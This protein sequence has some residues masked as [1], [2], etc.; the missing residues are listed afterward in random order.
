MCISLLARCDQ[1]RQAFVRTLPEFRDVQHPSHP[2]SMQARCVR[3]RQ[4]F[5]RTLPELEMRSIDHTHKVPA[6]CDTLGF[7]CANIGTHR[8]GRSAGFD[9]LGMSL[10]LGDESTAN[11]EE[12]SNG[13]VFSSTRT[14]SERHY[15]SRRRPQFL[16]HRNFEAAGARFL[17]EEVSGT[18]SFNL[19]SRLA[20]SS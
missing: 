16:F 1:H 8:D 15:F 5:V 4:A 13:E 2:Q 14:S 10:F 9:A 7:Q 18:I 3:H 20:D 19:T 12:M 11:C 6:K 17:F